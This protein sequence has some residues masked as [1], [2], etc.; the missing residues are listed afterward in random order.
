[1]ETILVGGV[2]LLAVIFVSWTAASAIIDRL[3]ELRRPE[4]D[5]VPV[6]PTMR[7]ITDALAEYR[8]LGPQAI[9]VEPSFDFDKFIERKP[10][11]DYVDALQY[12]FG[13]PIY[14]SEGVAKNSMLVVNAGMS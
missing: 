1:M 14:R 2:M 3:K 8:S 10:V 11:P 9:F 6:G 7:D 13:I 5:P 4:P 12:S